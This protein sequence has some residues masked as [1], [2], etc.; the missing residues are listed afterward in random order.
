MEDRLYLWIGHRY[1]ELPTRS[2]VANQSLPADQFDILVPRLPR[3]LVNKLDYHP[4]HFLL[5]HRANDGRAIDLRVDFSLFAT[6]ADLGTGLP[7]HLMPDRD[8]NRLDAFLEQ[9]QATAPPQDREFVAFNTAHR[10][11]TR[12]RLSSDWKRYVEVKENE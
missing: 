6:L 5:R 4:D 8:L 1:H 3:R 2:Y 12:I 10:L 9:L 7:R 11:A